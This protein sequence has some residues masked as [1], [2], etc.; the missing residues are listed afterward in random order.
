MFSQRFRLW[1]KS[2]QF[3]NKTISYEEYCTFLKTLTR[4]TYHQRNYNPIVYGGI[5]ICY[6]IMGIELSIC[7]GRWLDIGYLS[8]GLTKKQ[9]DTLIYLIR[10]K[11]VVIH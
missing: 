7:G 8:Y 2:F 9:A 6:D 1:F 5:S 3:V 10:C 11:I 4:V